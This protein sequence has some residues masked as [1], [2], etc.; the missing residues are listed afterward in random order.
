MSI[1][2]GIGMGLGAPMKIE[3]YWYLV[4]MCEAVGIDSIWHSDQLLRPSLEPIAMLAALAVAT[5]RLRFGMNAVVVSHR[6]PLVIAKECAT[7]DYLAPGRLLPVFGIGDASDPVWKATG[8]STKGRGQRATEAITLIRRLLSEDD[9][10]F[11]GEYFQYENAS[12][13]PR[14]QRPIPIWIGG[15]SEAAIQRTAALGDGWLGG[16]T[17]PKTAGDVVARIKVALGNAGRHIDDD[18]YGVVVP[19]RI[20]S[21]SD[22]AVVSFNTAIG[23][24]RGTALPTPMIAVGDQAAVVDAFRQYIDVGISKFVAIPLGENVQDIQ[25]Q[26]QR[27]AEDICPKVES[28]AY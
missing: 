2:I 5:K 6:D 24:R 22:P 16:L 4:Q 21:A 19:Y 25:A 10:T 12:I 15:D 23:A 28:R 13:A 26:V 11:Q 9:V 17:A 8:R 14:P 3:Q 27:L 18:H 7:I 20:G 1:R